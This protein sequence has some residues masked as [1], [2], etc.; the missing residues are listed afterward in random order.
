MGHLPP[1]GSLTLLRT[2]HFG[3]KGDRIQLEGRGHTDSLSRPAADVWVS[4][5][6][7]QSPGSFWTFLPEYLNPHPH[8]LSELILMWKMKGAFL[9][10]CTQLTMFYPWHHI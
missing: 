2:F 10:A 9:L 7:S 6:A 4:H 3:R 8:S 5:R 1:W